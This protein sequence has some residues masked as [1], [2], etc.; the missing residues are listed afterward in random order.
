M[1]FIF[2]SLPDYKQT[3]EILCDYPQTAEGEISQREA[4]SRD[5]IL[6]NDSGRVNRIIKP[7]RRRKITGR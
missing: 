7:L 2:S 3:A 4:L 5:Q 1:K 6:M